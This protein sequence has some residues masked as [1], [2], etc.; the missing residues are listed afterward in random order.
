M[1]KKLEDELS[2]DEKG[3]FSKILFLKLYLD[4]DPLSLNVLNI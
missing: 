3:V 2:D 1:N 4:E